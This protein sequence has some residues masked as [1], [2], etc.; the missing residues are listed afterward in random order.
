[1]IVS[2]DFFSD[3]ATTVADAKRKVIQIAEAKQHAYLSAS[4]SPR[5]TMCHVSPRREEGKPAR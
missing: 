2:H 5:W 3:T 1:V 4:G